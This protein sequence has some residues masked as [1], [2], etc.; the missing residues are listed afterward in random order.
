MLPGPRHRD[1]Q[2][3]SDPPGLKPEDIVQAEG[4]P[5]RRAQLIRDQEHRRTDGLVDKYRLRRVRP[6]QQR[7]RQPRPDRGLP[8][9][10]RTPEDVVRPSR[11]P[12]PARPQIT[13]VLQ[14]RSG[15]PQP[16]VLGHILGI[17]HTPRSRWATP[18]TAGRCLSQS[19]PSG[20]SCADRSAPC[21][22]P[23]QIT[24][25]S[26]S[27]IQ[28]GRPNSGSSKKAPRKRADPPRHA[29]RKSRSSCRGHGEP[30]PGQG[31]RPWSCSGARDR[32]PQ[33]SRC[34]G[35][36]GMRALR[37]GPH[38][39]CRPRRRSGLPLLPQ[40]GWRIGGGRPARGTPQ[41]SG[42]PRR[43]ARPRPEGAGQ[44][45]RDQRPYGCRRRVILPAAR[46]RGLSAS[47]DRRAGR[48]ATRRCGGLG[49]RRDRRG[50]EILPPQPA[51]AV[52]RRA[53]GG[54]CAGQPGVRVGVGLRVSRA[55][56]AII[57]RPSTRWSQLS[58]VL[59]GTKLA[60]LSWSMI[61]PY[62]HRT[63]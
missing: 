3:L 15:R 44:G 26:S 51:C 62:S 9:Q 31:G 27:R 60:A 8:A 55:P 38:T 23:I 24:L 45:T 40:R 21:P 54:G 56:S 49:R 36:P 11:P 50:R 63:R 14:I 22:S 20:S 42:R 57:P 18:K 34:R 32:L 12:S 35:G 25:S 17:G 33:C 28:R 58:A 52:R 41:G 59:S 39:R 30:R 13:D 29:S 7:L 10:T 16:H 53:P 47:C 1:V 4:H 43:P 5:L 37:P 48:R 19:A 2:H 6:C 46:A 61:I